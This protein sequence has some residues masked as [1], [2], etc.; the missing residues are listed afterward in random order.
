MKSIRQRS[1]VQ[2]IASKL[3]AI[4][5]SNKAK[6]K[7]GKIYYSLLLGA[8]TLLGAP[9]IATRSDRTLLVCY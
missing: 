8:R 4:T 5:I 3:E 7:G 9:G 6:R 1:K 2:A